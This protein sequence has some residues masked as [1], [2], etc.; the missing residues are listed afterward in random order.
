M[1]PLRFLST[2]MN[3]SVSEYHLTGDEK[4]ERKNSNREMSNEFKTKHVI[5]KYKESEYKK[6]YT[7]KNKLLKDG[8]I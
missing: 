6:Y 3:N 1:N 4:N 8:F 5:N 2:H 7:T